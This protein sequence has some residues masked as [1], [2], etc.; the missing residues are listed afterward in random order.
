MQ[1]AV[2]PVAVGSWLETFLQAGIDLRKLRGSEALSGTGGS[3][4]ISM[5]Q[6]P[7]DYFPFGK[8]SHYFPTSV[9]P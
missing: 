1:K 8:I 2:E 7:F 6:S 4:K 5:M 9:R 3:E